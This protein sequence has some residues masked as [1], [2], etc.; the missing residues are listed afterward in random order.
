MVV[1]LEVGAHDVVRDVSLNHIL[2]LL[3]SVLLLLCRSVVVLCPL[4]GILKAFAA[5]VP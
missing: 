5:V 3:L 1:K 4:V 2:S